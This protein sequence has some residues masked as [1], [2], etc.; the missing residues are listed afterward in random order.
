MKINKS[1]AA[2]LDIIETAEYIAQ[3][4]MDAAAR[5]VD[6]VDESLKL[7]VKSPDIGVIRKVGKA[8]EMRMWAVKGF[9]NSL[10]FYR[11]TATEINLIRVIHSARDFYRIL[12]D[13]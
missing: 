11:T 7:L 8:P 1:A 9:P 4:N 13:D 10:L 12:T 2:L 3:D 6:S 5:F